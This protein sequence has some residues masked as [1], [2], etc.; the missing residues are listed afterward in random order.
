MQNS[1]LEVG[2]QGLGLCEDVLMGMVIENIE[3]IARN[4]VKCPCSG[5]FSMVPTSD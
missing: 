4:G 5:Y 1:S 2:M 3:N